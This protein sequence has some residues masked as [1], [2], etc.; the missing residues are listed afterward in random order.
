MGLTGDERDDVFEAQAADDVRKVRRLARIATTTLSITAMPE[1]FEDLVDEPNLQ[2]AMSDAYRQAKTQQ[3]HPEEGLD[4]LIA[5]AAAVMLVRQRR[6]IFCRGAEPELSPQLSIWG[7]FGYAVVSALCLAVNILDNTGIDIPVDAQPRSRAGL[8]HHLATV[9][10]QAVGAYPTAN[11]VETIARCLHEFKDQSSTPPPEPPRQ[12]SMRQLLTTA[13]A[14]ALVMLL[15]GL[16]VWQVPALA[17]SAGQVTTSDPPSASAPVASPIALLPKNPPTVPLSQTLPNTV[18]QL[19]AYPDN[20]EPDAKTETVPGLVPPASGP[21][22][23]INDRLTFEVWLSI[24]DQHSPPDTVSLAINAVSPTT[25]MEA[26]RIANRDYPGKPEADLDD[27]SSVP[28]PR[29]AVDGTPTIYRFVL[30]AP[31]SNNTI[32]YWCGYTPKPVSIL[33]TKGDN[34]ESVITSYPVYVVRDE[35]FAGNPC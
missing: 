30:A 20:A 4:H 35:L 11:A 3:A 12:F 31:P 29:I 25:I 15:V 6:R 1:Q 7:D 28:V 23:A 10:E 17:G 24:R 13:G 32:G 2:Q 8:L 18:V 19:F 33:V 22:M 14:T 34:D 9:D 27:G 5:A 26:Q 16:A 21:V